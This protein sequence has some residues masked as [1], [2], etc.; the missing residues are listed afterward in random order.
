MPEAN[1]YLFNHKELLELLIKK[2]DLHEGK[3]TL[4]ANMGFSPGNF[5]STPDQMSP[6]AAVIVLQMGIQRADAQAPPEMVMDAAVMN[7]SPKTK[8]D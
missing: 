2:A 1:Q 5:A 8:K 3:W 6:G 7:P 4:M